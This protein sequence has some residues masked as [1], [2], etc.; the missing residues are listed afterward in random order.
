MQADLLPLVTVVTASYNLIAKGREKHVRQCIESV[1]SQTYPNIEHLVIDGA[2]TDGTIELLES[3]QKKGWLRCISEPDTGIYNAMNK[4]IAQA[5]GKYIAFLNSDDYWDSPHGVEASVH[6]LEGTRCDFSYAPCKK[7]REDGSFVGY[8]D[9]SIGSFVC[10]MP[11]C[12]QTMFTK[13]KTIRA[14]GG[15]DESFRLSADYNLIQQMLLKGIPCVEVPLNFTSF[16]LA[17]LSTGNKGIQLSHA[18]TKQIFRNLYGDFLTEEYGD[19][20]GADIYTRHLHG[21]VNHAV[22][23]MV[24]SSVHSDIARAVRTSIIPIGGN[25]YFTRFPVTSKHAGWQEYQPD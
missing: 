5:K 1:H 2:S 11:F 16:R 10:F 24:L 25:L 12:H 13:T 17:G 7:I 22:L 18:E 15:F 4:G 3:Y 20:H 14:F 23:E 6:M 9:T 21:I 19:Y 8:Q